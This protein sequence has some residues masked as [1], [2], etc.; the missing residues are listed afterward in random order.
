MHNMSDVMQ[1]CIFLG[2]FSGSVCIISR[3]GERAESESDPCIGQDKRGSNL[4]TMECFMK[5]VVP[6]ALVLSSTGSH[7]MEAPHA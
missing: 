5:G 4:T 3:L 7:P 6:R 2:M 1:D